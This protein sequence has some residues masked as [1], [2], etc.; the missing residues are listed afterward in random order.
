M[1]FFSSPD[2]QTESDAYEPTMHKHRWAKNVPVSSGN[3]YRNGGPTGHSFQAGKNSK[4]END[5]G[6]TNFLES[7]PVIHINLGVNW[8]SS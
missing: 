3:D 2:R 6:Q 5:H 4:K 8:A 7:T 1:N